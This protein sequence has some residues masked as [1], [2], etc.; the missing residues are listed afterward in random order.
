MTARVPTAGFRRRAV[1]AG[2]GLAT[3]LVAT[4]ALAQE[5]SGELVILQWQGGTDA[6]MWKKVEADFVAKNPG[7]TVRELVITGAGR[8][9]RRHPHGAARRRN[10]R[11]HHQHLA[12]LPRGTGRCRASCGRSIE[13]W[14]GYGWDQ[15]LTQSWKDLGS[16]D[17]VDL[18]PHLHLR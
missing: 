3:L 14:A 10:G 16:I 11:R 13:Q 18:R 15:K 6:E 17:G 2:I 7:V 12:G 8:R 5:L 9:A 4:P 1:L